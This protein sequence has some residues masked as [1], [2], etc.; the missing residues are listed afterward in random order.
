[1]ITQKLADFLLFKQIIDKMNEK[2]H[3]NLKGLEEIINI[4]ASLNNGLSYVLKEVF[5][6][7]NIVNRLMIALKKILN[8]Y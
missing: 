5:L 8:S 6:N 4:K 2:K 3:L 1:M 7:V